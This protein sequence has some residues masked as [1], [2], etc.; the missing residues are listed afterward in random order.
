KFGDVLAKTKKKLDEAS[1]TIDQAEVRTRAM[2]R[3]L[4]SVES[5]PEHRAQQLL[6]GLL[7]DDLGDAESDAPDGGNGG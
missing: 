3:Q 2:S 1:K 6:P 7:A 5:L 4:R